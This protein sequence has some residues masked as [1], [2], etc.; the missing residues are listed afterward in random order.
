MLP[1]QGLPMA[2]VFEHLFSN[3][4][5]RAQRLVRRKAIWLVSV[6]HLFGPR[7]VLGAYWFGM[8]DIPGLDKVRPAAASRIQNSRKPASEEADFRRGRLEVCVDGVLKRAIDLPLNQTSWGAPPAAHMWGLG[9]GET[10][11]RNMDLN[12]SRSN[13]AMA[14]LCLLP[15]QVLCFFGIPSLGFPSRPGSVCE[16]S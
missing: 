8:F 3:F 10:G 15:N 16:S 12:V 7:H 1:R 13:L 5:A 2:M 14:V 11:S 6:G 9:R 4:A